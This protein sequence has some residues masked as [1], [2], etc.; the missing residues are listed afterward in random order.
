[1]KQ[2]PLV[3]VFLLPTIFCLLIGLCAKTYA[4]M[5][6]KLMTDNSNFQAVFDSL[7]SILTPYAKTLV[8]KNDEIDDFHVNTKFIMK[9]NKPMY[10]GAV[11]INK[12]YVS[13][14][15]MP[16]YVFP[17]L[18]ENIS[19]KL[20]R[21]MQGKSCFNFKTIDLA[22]FKELTVLTNEGYIEY[23]NSGYL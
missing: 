21:R 7:K 6:G 8:I 18:I 1:V 15:L 4:L 23:K 2:V 10:F 20:Q 9:N 19:P 16:V 11:K 14:H 22:L 3:F 12:N 5:K 13:F 17:N